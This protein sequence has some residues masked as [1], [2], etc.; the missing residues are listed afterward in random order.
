M[1][2][3]GALRWQPVI[4]NRLNPVQLLKLALLKHLIDIVLGYLLLL[5]AQA[6]IL[7]EQ[8]GYFELL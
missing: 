5:L 1:L 6:N 4:I 7:K 3:M 2:F 8:S